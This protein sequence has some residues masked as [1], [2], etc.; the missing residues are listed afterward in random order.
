MRRGWFLILLMSLVPLA[1]AA[2]AEPN[3]GANAALKYWLA[4]ANM[5]F[6]KEQEKILEEWNKVPLD[7]K[8]D[9]LLDNARP[10]LLQLHRGA[11]I[12]RCDWGLDYEDGVGMLLPHLAKARNL[13]RVAALDIRR[14]LARQNG[15]GAVQTGLDALTMARHTNSDFTL[16]SILVRIVNEATVFEA[17]ATGLPKLDAAS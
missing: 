14:E 9:K 3:L 1:S 17:L 16:I 11:Q 2:G 4:F 10:M 15:P 5:N 12:E 7:V 6:D 8:A 13:T